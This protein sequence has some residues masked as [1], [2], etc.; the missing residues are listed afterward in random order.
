MFAVRIYCSAT[1]VFLFLFS[2]LAVVL[3]LRGQV[4]SSGACPLAFLFFERLFELAPYLLGGAAALAEA[5]RGGGAGE[6]REGVPGAEGAR[7]QE[8]GGA[9]S[10][11]PPG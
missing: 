2:Q 7:P 3:R 6:A 8:A 11:S 4:I 10:L 1:C 9:P 5:A